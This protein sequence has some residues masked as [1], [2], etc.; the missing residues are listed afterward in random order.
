MVRIADPAQIVDTGLHA[1][2]QS[3]AGR[4]VQVQGEAQPAVRRTICQLRGL[5]L[6]EGPLRLA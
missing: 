1:F 2:D 5:L 4:V 6:D 3:H